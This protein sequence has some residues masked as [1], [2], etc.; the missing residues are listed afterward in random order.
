MD[1][2][3]IISDVLGLATMISLALAIQSQ[4]RVKDIQPSIKSILM[5]WKEDAG[6]KKLIAFFELVCLYLI[7]IGITCT[8]IGFNSDDFGLL[9]F[10]FEIIVFCAPIFLYSKVIGF[11]RRQ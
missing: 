6:P 9:G 4:N 2:E 10:V 5:F 3:F 7:L 1:T 11:Y 8:L